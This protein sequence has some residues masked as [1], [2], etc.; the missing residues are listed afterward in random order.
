[1]VWLEGYEIR[2]RWDASGELGDTHIRWQTE[3]KRL[4]RPAFHDSASEDGGTV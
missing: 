4:T 2:Q 1:M 3:H